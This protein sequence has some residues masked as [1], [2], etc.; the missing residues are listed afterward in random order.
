[1]KIKIE[2]C[3]IRDGGVFVAYRSRMVLIDPNLICINYIDRSPRVHLKGRF[4]TTQE[5][6]DKALIDLENMGLLH[7]HIAEEVAK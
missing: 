6:Y 4:K 5:A 3:T 1:M 7:F 2:I